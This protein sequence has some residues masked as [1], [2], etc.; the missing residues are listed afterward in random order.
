MNQLALLK[1]STAPP[2]HLSS[3]HQRTVKTENVTALT[4]DPFNQ[5]VSAADD[6]SL[7]LSFSLQHTLPSL[8]LSSTRRHT[9]CL[10]SRAGMC[11]RVRVVKPA[12]EFD[13]RP[14]PA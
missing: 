3:S 10:F 5:R 14:R 9:R 1:P 6:N 11:V 13:N 8:S 4:T 7:P 2:P 12:S